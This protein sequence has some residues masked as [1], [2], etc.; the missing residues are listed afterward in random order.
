MIARDLVAGEGLPLREWSYLEIAHATPEAF[1]SHA[2][3]GLTPRARLRLA[4]LIVNGGWSAILAAR[5]F[6]VQP[7]PLAN[8]RTGTGPRG[9]AGMSYPSSRPQSM[10]MRAPPDVVKRIVAAR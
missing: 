5:M 8:G 3:A 10:P 2:N 9:S 1:V 7:S 6:M 4:R